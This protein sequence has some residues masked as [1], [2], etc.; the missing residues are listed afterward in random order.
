MQN[1]DYHP[2]VNSDKTIQF[3]KIGRQEVNSCF[4]VEHIIKKKS[5]TLIAIPNTSWQIT[6]TIV[7]A[8]N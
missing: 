6:S 3:Q 5:Q 4:L 8:D 2:T 1:P 7:R